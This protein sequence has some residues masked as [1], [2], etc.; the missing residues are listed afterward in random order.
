M[1]WT[2]LNCELSDWL[3]LNCELLLN[4]TTELNFL[5]WT[6]HMCELLLW[7]GVGLNC[8]LLVEKHVK[9]IFCG[10]EN[11]KKWFWGF[12]A[13]FHPDCWV[14]TQH[15]ETNFDMWNLKFTRKNRFSR[16]FLIF[17]KWSYF[18]DSLQFSSVQFSSVHLNCSKVQ[19]FRITRVYWNP[20]NESHID[21]LLWLRMETL[22]TLWLRKKLGLLISPLLLVI[23]DCMCLIIKE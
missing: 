2:E 19:Q 10:E 20:S 4:W 11:V 22:F 9:V 3:N 15:L 23:W 12:F 16:N 13:W 1:N 18:K 6:A 8:E 7:T 21:Y 14:Q 5:N 17:L